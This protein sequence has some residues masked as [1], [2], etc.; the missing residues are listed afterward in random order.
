MRVALRTSQAVAR[1]LKR[2]IRSF[3]TGGRAAPAELTGACDVIVKGDL[4]GTG[5]E[6]EG[7]AAN[8]AANA[9]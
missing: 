7:M 3:A 6:P 1:Q 9:G 4:A 2:V 8:L 5:D